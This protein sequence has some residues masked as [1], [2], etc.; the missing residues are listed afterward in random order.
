[1]KLK[2][3]PDLVRHALK[4]ISYRFVAT[5]T[6]IITLLLF[7]VPLSV[8]TLIGFGELLVKPVIYFVHERIWYNW[9]RIK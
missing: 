5:L 3:N 9:I 2:T 6:T 8:S 4:T 1:M 7:E